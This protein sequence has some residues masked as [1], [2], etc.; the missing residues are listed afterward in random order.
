MDGVYQ[1]CYQDTIL[2]RSNDAGGDSVPNH[3]Q[4]GQPRVRAH[5]DISN[6]RVEVPTRLM[7]QE[8]T[9]LICIG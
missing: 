9:V 2:S 8:R 5:I 6:R 4:F 7:F 3:P 1:I